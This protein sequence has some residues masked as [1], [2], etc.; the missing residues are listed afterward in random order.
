MKKRVNIIDKQDWNVKEK[1]KIKI[2]RNRWVVVFIVM[3]K[4]PQRRH[5]VTVIMD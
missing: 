5:G 1:I 3:K 4:L 2:I